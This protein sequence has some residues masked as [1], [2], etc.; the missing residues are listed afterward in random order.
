MS[1]SNKVPRLIVSLTRCVIG[2]SQVEATAVRLVD[3]VC[4]KKQRSHS[5]ANTQNW[6]SIGKYL[7]YIALSEGNVHAAEDVPLGRAQKL[8]RCQR[9]PP[10]WSAVCAPHDFFPRQAYS[11][12]QRDKSRGEQR[13]WHTYLI[14]QGQQVVVEKD[15]SGRK[16]IILIVFHHSEP[17]ER[18]ISILT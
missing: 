15:G 5:H 10:C 7:F 1:L 11:T 9:T 6:Y 4:Q 17:H 3:L 13:W 14:L 8:S 12:F 18:R 16:R 2:G